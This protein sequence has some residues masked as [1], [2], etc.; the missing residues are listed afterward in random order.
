MTL[1]TKG[2]VGSDVIIIFYY[3][4]GSTH[5]VMHISTILSRLR[6]TQQDRGVGVAWLTLLD[7]PLFNRVLS[8]GDDSIVSIFGHE[9]L[10][11]FETIRELLFDLN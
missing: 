10:L 1:W 3:L 11:S 4:I 6:S 9:V 2:A 5:I 8:V 7:L